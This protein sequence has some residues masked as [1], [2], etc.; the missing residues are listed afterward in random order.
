MSRPDAMRGERKGGVPR[1]LFRP[2]A[3]TIIGFS[4]SSGPSRTLLANLRRED[5]RFDGPVHLVNPAR[6]ARGEDGYLSSP[7]DIAGP[8]GFVHVLLTGETAVAAVRGLTGDITA[9]AVYGGGFGDAGRDDL[10]Q[11]LASWSA[12][13]PTGHRVPV[14]GPQS[15]G[16]YRFGPDTRFCGITGPAPATARPGQVAF[17]S[18]SGAL[19]GA[20]L[21]AAWCKGLGV[22][23]AVSIGN[24]R[25]FSFA[26]AAVAALAEDEITILCVYVEG[27]AHLADLATVGR[28]AA[29][30]GKVVLLA[31]GG[32]SA[33]GRSLAQSHTGSLA[34]DSAV[35]RGVARQYGIVQV[36]SVEELLWGAE[37]IGRAGPA[38]LNR[39]R[40]DGVALFGLTGGGV[41][42][43]AD[44]LGRRGIPLLP[45]TSRGARVIARVVGTGRLLNPLDGG[46]AALAQGSSLTELTS[47]YAADPRYRVVAC[48]AGM[49]LP[50]PTPNHVHLYDALAAACADH[51]KAGVLVSPLPDSTSGA[52]DADGLVVA[53]GIEEGALKIHVLREVAR[54]GAAVG[55]RAGPAAAIR[56]TA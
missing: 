2:P 23:C 47:A 41:I 51:G 21:R 24:G 10:E 14:L 5:C 44:A 48:V 4:E 7:G 32:E 19:V 25:G 8:L 17:V 3:A 22:G 38:I 45:P 50:P 9:V 20:F 53:R 54:L 42:L 28:Y 56:A 18:Q 11:D 27:V 13:N 43:V 46:A 37:A 36:A 40:D 35:V 39:G 6:A 1:G 26:D 29:Q 49:G 30:Q 33:G 15:M 55:R 12:D 52:W 34:T 31:V 16:I